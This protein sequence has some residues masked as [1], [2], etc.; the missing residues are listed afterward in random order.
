MADDAP[1]AREAG[2][3]ERA[4][5]AVETGNRVYEAVTG[6]IA[7]IS[8]ILSFIQQ[9]GV[10][11]ILVQIGIMG[12]A[13]YISLFIAVPLA[14]GILH[15]LHGATKRTSTDQ[16]VAVILVVVLVAVALLVRFG[17]F[18]DGIGQPGDLDG[19]GTAFTALVGVLV[20]LAPLFVLWWRKGSVRTPA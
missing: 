11:S 12:F 8:A 18:Y 9:H 1:D 4:L 2:L 16:A 10:V 7:A 5:H 14:L 20:L 6:A 15:V 17:L 3:P 13:L 19:I